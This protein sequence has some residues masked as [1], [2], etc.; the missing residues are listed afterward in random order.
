M[1]Q[2]GD[3]IGREGRAMKACWWKLSGLLVGAVLL[4]FGS[5]SA[6]ASAPPT[7]LAV[8]LPSQLT[9]D[10]SP[11]M[12]TV[13]YRD[14]DGDLKEARFHVI[15][16]KF[17][18]FT[19]DLEGSAAPEGEFPFTVSCTIAQEVTLKLVLVDRAGLRSKPKGFSFTCGVP[20]QGNYDQ[21]QTTVRPTRYTLGLNLFILEDGVNTLSEGAA[22]P[23]NGAILGQPRREVQLAVERQVV[24]AVTG[25]WDQCGVEYE[26]QALRVVRSQKLKLSEGSL[27]EL[28]FVRTPG[29]LPE[30]A[31]SDPARKSPLEVLE[32]ALGPLGEALKAEG[33]PLDPR[34]LNVFITGARIVFHAGDERHFGGVTTL[35]G[36]I[37]L[38][39][40]DAI[41]VINQ[42]TGE[43]FPPKRPIT[44]IAHELGHNFNLEHI[45]P[46]EDPL[47]LMLS[48][49]GQPTAVPPQPTVH[50]LPSQ[51][52]QAE[53]TIRQLNLR[54]PNQSE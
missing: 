54:A 41:W 33:S 7:I 48:V 10:G 34:A 12:G 50:L 36:R 4:P 13:R 49:S 32:E 11:I 31:I 51:C 15:D 18:P 37:S 3:G 28:L 23:D 44:A 16:G 26:L 45:S 22:F 8:K 38:V 47:N 6:D 25:I 40:W 14:P 17:D 43:I 39:R 2:S 1:A 53:P 46:R 35:G 42:K 21:E 29:R 19:I 27:D 20:P 9:L 52:E 24:P 30:V 5:L